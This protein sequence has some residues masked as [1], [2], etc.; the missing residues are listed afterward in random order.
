MNIGAGVHEAICQLEQSSTGG[1]VDS[2]MPFRPS[3][4]T[5]FVVDSLQQFS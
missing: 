4:M 3:K 5:L 2:N 1:A